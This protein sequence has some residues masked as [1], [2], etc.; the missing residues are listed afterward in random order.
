MTTWTD[1]SFGK[2]LQDSVR[3]EEGSFYSKVAIR[4]QP[5]N[6]YGVDIT[7][8]TFW[9]NPYF[10]KTVIR[11]EQMPAN[12]GTISIRDARHLYSLSDYYSTETNT[13]NAGRHDLPGL[14]TNTADKT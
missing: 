11:S 8:K 5:A 2:L 4:Y 14:L 12:P 10:A 13:V 3:R 6:N 1:A 9:F 7:P